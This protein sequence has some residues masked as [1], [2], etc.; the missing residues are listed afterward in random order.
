MKVRLICDRASNIGL[1]T[2]G[3]ILDLAP[4]E[5]IRLVNAGQALPVELIRETAVVENV[6]KRRRGRPP[7]VLTAP[8]GES[9]NV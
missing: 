7:K 2:A 9:D 1:I 6:E 3:S 4:A 5:A 8:H